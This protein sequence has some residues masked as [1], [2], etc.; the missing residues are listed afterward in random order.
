MDVTISSL[1]CFRGEQPVITGLS[2]H[3]AAGTALVLRGP[4]GSG[5]STLLRALAGLLPIAGGDAKIGGISLRKDVDGYQEKL[6]YA[7]HLDANKSALTV[8]ENLTFWSRL[9]GDGDITL[10]LEKFELAEIAERRAAAGSAGQKRRLGRA[11]LLLADR[12]LR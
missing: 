6:A 12:P 9:F 2:R 11:R 1:T 10:A 8:R 5:K 7:G 4:N 3:V